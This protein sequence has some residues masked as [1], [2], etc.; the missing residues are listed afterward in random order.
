M[1]RT[2]VFELKVASKSIS[3]KFPMTKFWLKS[4]SMFCRTFPRNGLN[5]VTQ[6]LQKTENFPFQMLGTFVFDLKIASKLFS[7]KLPMTNLEFYSPW[8]LS[9][10]FPE[11]VSISSLKNLRKT[12]KCLFQTLRTFVFEFKVASKPFSK[13]LP[14]TKFW[15]K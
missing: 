14:M 7:K 9:L 2:F 12:E 6:R 4:F 11:M 3:K 15:F 10:A 8:K 1:L 5:F 13:K